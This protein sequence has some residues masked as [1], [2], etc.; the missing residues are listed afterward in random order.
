MRQPLSRAEECAAA[1]GAY[2]QRGSAMA[3]PS[4]DWR[5]AGRA[6]RRCGTPHLRHACERRFVRE[7]QVRVEAAQ[8]CN[9][10]HAACNTQHAICNTQHA[11]CNMRRH[12]LAR[13]FRG[14]A[15]GRRTGRHLSKEVS[16]CCASRCISASWGGSQSAWTDVPTTAHT[17]HGQLA[18]PAGMATWHGRDG[19]IK[20][21]ACN[22]QPAALAARHAAS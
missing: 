1:H 9:M 8:P 18:R 5:L 10:Q 11:I 12:A 6:R 2:G 19:C 4:L 7:K 15:G 22:A 13:S 17:W 14:R 3:A 20:H 21:A 16:R